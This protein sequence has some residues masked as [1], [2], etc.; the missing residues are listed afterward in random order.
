MKDWFRFVGK[1]K[2]LLNFGFLFNFFSSF[3]QTFFISL[4]VPFW[5]TSFE[6]SNASFGVLYASV[7]I[8]S[9][10]LLSI[11][12][13]FIDSM[14]L[15][16]FSFIVFTGLIMSTIILSQAN[17]LFVLMIGLLLVR[18]F[19]QGLMTHTAATGIA[20]YFDSNRGKALGFTALGNPA[21]QFFLP[22]LVVPLIAFTGWQYSLLYLV[23]LA[24]LV[25]LPTIWTIG[26]M[27]DAEVNTVAKTSKVIPKERYLK[28]PQFWLIAS[29]IFVIP[30]IGTAIFLY[31]FT[32]GQ[33]KGWDAAWVS[34]SFA[35]FA[36][37]SAASLLFSGNL[38]DRYSGIKLF[39]LYLIPTVAALLVIALIDHKWVFPLFYT[40][41]GISSGLGSTVKTA[42]QVEVYG[43]SNLGK[44]RSYFSTM[45]V[46]STALG[47]PV[48]GYF[49]DHNFSFSTIMLVTAG[50]VIG[51]IILSFKLSAKVR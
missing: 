19:G 47:P 23:V 2:R 8:I 42:M 22:L 37:F 13:R 14:S 36:V 24:L 41:L 21:G 40:L 46:L 3:G 39:P 28:S 45:L 33:S 48:F 17:T 43:K 9:A 6:I 20:V 18:F 29:N 1:N 34:F 38:V 44:I 49:I 25:V 32:I 4:F 50:I 27:D 35:F 10:G 7:T 51:I 31:Q 15:R 30:F 16:N 11:S 5:I 26:N 12:G